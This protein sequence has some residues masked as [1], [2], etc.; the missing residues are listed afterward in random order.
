[1]KTVT[2]SEASYQF[3]VDELTWLTDPACLDRD[4]RS[5]EWLA[6]G[7]KALDE[8]Q[9]AKEVNKRRK[10]RNKAARVN[11]ERRQKEARPVTL[12]D[13]FKAAYS[14]PVSVWIEDHY[15][16]AAKALAAKEK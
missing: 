6:A 3:L 12:N 4:Y 5:D 9:K 11:R 16:E 10:L 14:E 8:L 15:L 2:L 1:V 13:L 7:D